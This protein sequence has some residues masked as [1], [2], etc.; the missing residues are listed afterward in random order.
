MLD[1]DLYE[2]DHSLDPALVSQLYHYST[3]FLALSWFFEALYKTSQEMLEE[4]GGANTEEGRIGG[5]S[6][7]DVGWLGGAS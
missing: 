2:V 6:L 1:R 5:G 3:M 7:Y 4:R